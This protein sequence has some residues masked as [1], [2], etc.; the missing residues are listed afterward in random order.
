MI[1]IALP[2]LFDM[3]QSVYPNRVDAFF[4]LGSV[5]GWEFLIMSVETQFIVF[6]VV[7]V[8]IAFVAY[9]ILLKYAVFCFQSRSRDRY[10]IEELKQR[11]ETK[12]LQMKFEHDNPTYHVQVNRR[13]KVTR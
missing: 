8:C 3:H 1:R 4:V 11:S 9:A 13:P 12:R 10:D 5:F 2:R 6:C 7:C